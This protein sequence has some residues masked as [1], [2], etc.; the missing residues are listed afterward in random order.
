MKSDCCYAPAVACYALPFK[1]RGE[2][3]ALLV[4][5]S[6]TCLLRFWERCTLL[7]WLQ[8]SLFRHLEA[9]HNAVR[10]WSAFFVFIFNGGTEQVTRG[11]NCGGDDITTITSWSGVGCG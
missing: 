7:L 4:P 6:S 3:V 5:G 1:K 2:Q 9:V 10:A 8:L 11:S